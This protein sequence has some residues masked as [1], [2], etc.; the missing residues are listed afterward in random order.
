MNKVIG[1]TGGIASGKSTV[2]KIIEQLGYTVVDA[3]IA[4]RIVVEP[5]QEA[6]KG[7]V[8]SFGEEILNEDQTL[9][10]EKLGSII[11]ND[12]KK[13]LQLNAI[14]HPAIRNYMDEEKNAAFARG[15]KVVFMDIPLLFES[16]LTQTV[17]LSILVYVDADVQL[18]RLMERNGLS[19]EDALARIRSQMPLSE[20]REL[21]DA[22][23]E[24]NETV[25]KT[26]QQLLDILKEWDIIH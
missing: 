23:I 16:K 20:K 9:N 15:E 21:A 6:Y 17:D 18:R 26:K 1:I 5:G 22:I 10:R 2:S 14:M 25:E 11:F 12:E 19:Q 7:V 24:N 13:R 3:D 8:A 4:A